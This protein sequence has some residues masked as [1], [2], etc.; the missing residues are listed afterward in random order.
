MRREWSRR[1]PPLGGALVA[2]LLAVFVLPSALNVPQ[3]NPTQTLEFAPVPPDDQDQPPPTGN[4]SQ[5][6]LGTSDTNPAADAFGGESPGLPPPPPVPEGTGTRPIT[7]RCVGNPPRQTEDP[8]SP[9]CV[10]YFDGDNGGAT[11]RG[12]TRDEVRVLVYMYAHYP[13][14]TA[15][16]W[17]DPPD[18]TYWDLWDPPS[19]DEHFKVRSL[20][21]YQNYFNER[22]QTYGR[23]V[24]MWVYFDRGNASAT[25]EGRIADALENIERIDPF[26][27]IAYPRGADDV[28][29]EA[30]AERGVMVFGARQ[31][32]R[33]HFLRRYPGMIWSYPASVELQARLYADWVCTNIVGEPVSFSGNGDV[34][35]PRVLA[36]L[37]S[38]D[39]RTMSHIH[40]AEEAKRR[41]GNCGGV[42]EVE[43]TFPVAGYAV[44]AEAGQS[45]GQVA[46]TN[47]ATFQQRDVTT[48]IWPQGFETHHSRAAAAVNYAPEWVIGGDGL[49]ES[50]TAAKFQDQSVWDQHAFVVTQVT[51]EVPLRESQCY[52]AAKDGS[53]QEFDG[54]IAYGCD[55]WQFYNNVR[56]L[57]TGIQVAGPNLTPESVDEGFHAIPAVPSQDPSMPA[58][59]YLPDDYTCV[60]DGVVE[61]WDATA[62]P[63]AFSEPGC[64]RMVDDGQRYFA[65]RWPEG[66]PVQLRSA[67]DPCNTWSQG[68]T[69]S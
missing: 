6:A 62:Q 11:S 33:E 40:Y 66:D 69:Y 67:D 42:F 19:D 32:H 16:G 35:Q 59:F 61:W 55:F 12:V 3:S 43:A 18:D 24:H 26:A 28:Y 48:V 60:K 65:G 38:A 57:F 5:L 10:G 47:I 25:P 22:Y 27:V 64:W 41:I 45:P 31:P 44:G 8:L 49:H 14:G 63:E 1:Y 23:R 54:D 13:D 53:S 21:S 37:R 7:K 20:R 34:G 4:V 9:P 50:N 17:E 2:A 58:C 51:A 39:E 15:R 56:Q 36:L 29:I 52:R 68:P 30:M 46:A